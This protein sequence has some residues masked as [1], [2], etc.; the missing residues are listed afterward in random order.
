MKFLIAANSNQLSVA[1]GEPVVTKVN[2]HIDVAVH[3]PVATKASI[4]HVKAGRSLN[5]PIA[6]PD[7]SLLI[8][9]KKKLLE[10]NPAVWGEKVADDN[11]AEPEWDVD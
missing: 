8:P 5:V 6:V 3:R 10:E 9:K 7:I 2:V 1:A 11:E 4:P